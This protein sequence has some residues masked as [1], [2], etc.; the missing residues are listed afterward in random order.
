MSAKYRH[1]R[2]AAAFLAAV[3]LGAAVQAAEPPGLPL[4]SKDACARYTG[5]P[6]HWGEDRRAGMV[7]VGGGSFVLG[8]RHGYADERAEVEAKVGGF[9]IDQTEVTVAQFAEFAKA[10]G[11]VTEAERQGSAAVFRPPSAQALKQKDYA[12]WNVVKGADWKHPDGP[13]SSAEP[14]RP[15]TL[16]TFNDASA[17]AHWLG[18]QLPTEAQWEFA[19]KAGRQGLDI[20]QEP[21]DRHGKPVANFWQGPFPQTNTAEDGFV[22]LAP[23]GCFPANRN[24]L[25]DMLG[26]AWEQTQDLYAGPHE[27]P[28]SVVKLTAAPVSTAPNRP[29]VIKGGS[30]LCGRDFCVRYRPS[31]REAHEANL[32]TSHIG[33]RTVAPD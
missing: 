7:H 14:N 10:T 8:T 21:R 18:R 27:P 6:P 4:G 2:L 19:A 33:F 23:V 16:V 15:V 25:Y 3:G 12:W 28:P 32:P 1:L 13:G 26:N 5:L 11:Y 9:W 20:E 22:G 29:L 24:G 30:H 17:Y 31:A